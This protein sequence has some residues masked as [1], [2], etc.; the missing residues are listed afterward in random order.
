MTAPL[1]RPYRASRAAINLQILGTGDGVAQVPGGGAMGRLV[2]Q[3]R[4]WMVVVTLIVPFGWI[5]P[6]LRAAFRIRGH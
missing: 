6:L 1:R 2:K 4:F 3:E 5:Y